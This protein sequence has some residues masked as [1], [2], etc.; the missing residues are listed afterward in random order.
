MKEAK[1]LE[2][3]KRQVEQRVR[4]WP[5]EKTA[6]VR[7]REEEARSRGATP[8]SF[9]KSTKTNEQR[10]VRVVVPT[11]VPHH[12]RVSIEDLADIDESDSDELRGVSQ[13]S[14]EIEKKA[15]QPGNGTQE[16]KKK[17]ALDRDPRTL[18]QTARDQEP[19]ETS[20]TEL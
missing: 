19:V 1:Y 18:G 13:Q 3:Q 6:A 8:S 10:K 15:K 16:P 17:T 20:C 14:K 4:R 7:V 12:A 2:E 5:R 9:A 11:E